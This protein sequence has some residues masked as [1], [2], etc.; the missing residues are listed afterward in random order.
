M[1]AVPLVGLMSVMVSVS[2]FGSLSFRVAGIVMATLRG[3]P[4]VSFTAVGGT[5]LT[6]VVTGGVVLLTRLV[7]SV[8]LLALATFVAL[9][10]NGDVTVSVRFVEVTAARFPSAHVTLPPLKL[11]PPLAL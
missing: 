6:M 9:P 4:T 5:L 3:V 8:E 10:F 7:S 2:P 1:L 11:P